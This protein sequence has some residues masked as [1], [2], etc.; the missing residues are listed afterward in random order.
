MHRLAW[1]AVTRL[2]AY[3]GSAD[4]GAAGRGFGDGQGNG[5]QGGATGTAGGTGIAGSVGGG[6][7]PGQLAQTGTP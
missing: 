4:A 7:T 1:F 5:R 6:C 3:L 2:L